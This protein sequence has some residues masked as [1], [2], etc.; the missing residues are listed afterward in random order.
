LNVWV[1]PSQEVFIA[2]P[3]PRA[4]TKS[5]IQ[6]WHFTW[7]SSILLLHHNPDAQSSVWATRQSKGT[8]MDDSRPTVLYKYKDISGCG[9]SHFEDLLSSNRLWYSSPNDFN[10]PF[11]CRCVYDVNNTRESIVN[12]L[13][14]YL[15]QRNG[16]SELDARNEAEREV[17]T[18]PQGV[19]VWQEDRIKLLSLQAANTGILCLTSSH[20]DFLMWTH[21]AGRHTGICIQFR[22]SDQ[23]DEGQL[24]FIAKAMRVEYSERCPI[25][26]L[27]AEESTEVVRKAFLTKAECFRHEQEWRQVRYGER[28]GMKDVPRGIVGAVIL[29]CQIER[30]DRDRVVELCAAYESDI[31]IVAAT[32]N[33]ERYA[34]AFELQDIV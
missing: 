13:V 19:K 24:G 25:I 18:G 28:S 5:T 1:T 8:T 32:L 17:S 22:I 26:N 9:M 34:L 30:K 27:V 4:F 15:M 20:Q 29:G 10:D 2:I 33:P 31:E 3:T 14:S 11:D 7:G 12:R 16:M 21:Y 23:S 6:A